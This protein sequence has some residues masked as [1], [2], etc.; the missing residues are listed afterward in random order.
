MKNIFCFFLTVL[1]LMIF[2]QSR[3]GFLHTSDI[4]GRALPNAV[5]Q[6][7]PASGSTVICEYTCDKNGNISYQVNHADNDYYFRVSPSV[8]TLQFFEKTETLTLH[9]GD[10]GMAYIQVQPANSNGLVI[11]VTDTSNNPLGNAMVELY[12]TERKWRVDSSCISTPFYTD[13]NGQLI[14]TSLLPIQYWFNVRSGYM[15]NRFTIKNTATPIDTSAL[16]YISI[17]LKDLSEKGFFM[18][19][20]CD[21]KTW[22]TD[23]LVIFGVSQQYSA[24]SRLLSDG[25]WSDSNGN[26]GYWWFNTDETKMSYNYDQDSPNGGGS[27][28]EATLIE[29]TDS[30][31][32]GD[33]TMMSLPVRYFMSDIVDSIDLS[34][35]ARDTVL[36]LNNNGT[37]T[38]TADGLLY[39]SAYSFNSLISLSKEQFTN[40]DLGDNTVYVTITD[41][42]GHAYTDTITVT[43]LAPT[44]MD[45]EERNAL[46][47][48]PNPAGD[49]IFIENNEQIK[50]IE[51]VDL[52]GKVLYTQ[53]GSEKKATLDISGLRKGIYIICVKT[54]K[55]TCNSKL[56]KN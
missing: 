1:P 5:V 32:V 4:G 2:S 43:I 24:D 49:F 11:T 20:L 48:F 27:T 51:V 9:A 44:G 18:C 25:T 46:K 52:M 47:I 50:T 33:M 45:I 38:L 14:I 17:P 21:N 7:T 10:N 36:Y 55:N 16:T 19:G 35:V 28:V 12:D 54:Q 37:A 40:S 56:I 34:I 39:T 41:R 23:S 13:T 8:Q 6:I 15:T 29:L 53:N 42:C 3:T 30:T 26:H 31:F 22:I